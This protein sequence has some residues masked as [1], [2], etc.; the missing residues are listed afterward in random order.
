MAYYNQL[1]Y[2]SLP[3]ASRVESLEAVLYTSS[4]V[5]NV[6]VSN[7]QG[8][9]ISNTI[10]INTISLP[11]VNGNKH[12]FSNRR[13]REITLS[14][15]LFDT[16]SNR[17]GLQK[18]IDEIENLLNPNENGDYNYVGFRFG[19]TNFFPCFLTNFNYSVS[20]FLSGNPAKLSAE[21]TLIE[22]NNLDSVEISEDLEST[23]IKLSDFEKEEAISLAGQEINDNNNLVNGYKSYGNIITG[24][25][26][27]VVDDTGIISIIESIT[28]IRAEIGIYNPLDGVIIWN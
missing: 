6:F 2:N 13:S 23:E 1:A 14:D 21:I 7:P 20:L 25:S 28:G 3:E 22:T 8:I 19:S 17:K 24:D 4:E 26:E 5:Y 9:A 15:I 18:V 27:L 12:V 10:D 16:Y 11:G